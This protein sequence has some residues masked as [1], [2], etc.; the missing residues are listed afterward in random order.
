MLIVVDGMPY[1]GPLSGINPN[2]I[3]SVKVLKD[4]IDTVIYGFRGSNGVILIE[5]KTSGSRSYSDQKKK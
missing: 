2:D 3:R 4:P 5:T 1:D